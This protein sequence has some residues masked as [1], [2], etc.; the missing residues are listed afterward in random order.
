MRKRI[1]SFISKLTYR[2]IPILILYELALVVYLYFS[3]NPY[4]RYDLTANAW[5]FGLGFLFLCSLAFFEKRKGLPLPYAESMSKSDYFVTGAVGFIGTL[6]MV[7]VIILLTA[8][9]SF[10]FRLSPFDPAN[11]FTVV[12]DF[13]F[14][15]VEESLKMGLTNVFGIPALWM[16]P[17]IAR[18]IWVL[19]AG[20]VSVAIWAY[21]HILTGSYYG[22]YASAN[23]LVAFLIGMILL[24]ITIWKR[25]FLP[26]VIV[27]GIYDVGVALGYWP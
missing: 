2:K 18:N 5:F 7:D 20:T 17:R 4:Q 21:T 9:G 24:A 16:R 14:G 8:Y 23:M 10:S 25:N 22:V 12:W 19:F 15:I 11:W 27:H 1:R 6:V 13:Q 3:P 26:A